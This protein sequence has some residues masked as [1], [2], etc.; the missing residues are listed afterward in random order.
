MQSHQM[1]IQLLNS[2]VFH[3]WE[4]RSTSA[5]QGY[6]RRSYLQFTQ[7]RKGLVSRTIA[8]EIGARS[9]I[10]AEMYVFQYHD[11]DPWYHQGNTVEIVLRWLQE[12]ST[13]KPC[14]K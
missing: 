12:G 7:K 14:I 11:Q 4:I 6:G 5:V 2:A 1:Y 13:A 3:G 10:R 8:V 9:A